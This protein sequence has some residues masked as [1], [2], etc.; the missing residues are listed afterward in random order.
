M[1]NQIRLDKD[2]A[3]FD[4]FEAS[5]AI[6]KLTFCE[7]TDCQRAGDEYR[8][9]LK[10]PF[11]ETTHRCASRRSAIS[12]ST[13][14]RWCPSTDL[15]HGQEELRY[16]ME[17]AIDLYD[18]V[19]DQGRRLHRGLKPTDVPPH[20]KSAVVVEL[21]QAIDDLDPALDPNS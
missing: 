8:I 15:P 4:E 21:V 12:P 9:T 6:S 16:R 11:G 13:G 19:V 17:P 5:N 18:S 20:H 1:F 2:G 3:E 7:V 14:A 10:T